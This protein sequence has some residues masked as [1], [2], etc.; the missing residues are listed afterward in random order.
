MSAADETEFCVLCLSSG[1]S[2]EAHVASI[3]RRMKEHARRSAVIP[4]RE[5]S[6]TEPSGV[7]GTR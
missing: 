6:T 5:D 2:R 3:A 7:L 1:H 4:Q